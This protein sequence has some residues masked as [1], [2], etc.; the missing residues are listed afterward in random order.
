MRDKSWLPIM[1]PKWNFF[2]EQSGFFMEDRL[3]R[4][5]Y[6]LHWHDFY[7]IELI[8][9]GRGRQHINGIAYDMAPGDLTLL[10]PSDFHSYSIDEGDGLYIIN[11]SFSEK[12]LDERTRSIILN[13]RTPLRHRFTGAE[14]DFIILELSR[15]WEAYCSGVDAHFISRYLDALCSNIILRSSDEPA[16]EKSGDAVPADVLGAITYI[17]SNFAQ[18]LKLED[19]AHAVHLSPNYLS[20]K[21]KHFLGI[22]FSDYLTGLRLEVAKTLLEATESPVSEIAER[23]GFESVSHFS[24]SFRK[25]YG[26]T[27]TGYRAG[28]SDGTAHLWRVST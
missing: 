20:A 10:T 4:K 5:P 14:N 11:I 24:Y 15:M 16:G 21:L 8:V 25:K 6:P 19:V 7:E 13:G 17:R 1:L 22:S 3:L 18:K 26:V 9:Y 12:M 28:L 27:P 23:S 2:S